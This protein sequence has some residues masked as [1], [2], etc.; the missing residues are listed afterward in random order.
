MPVRKVE[1]LPIPRP[2]LL[3]LALVAVVPLGLAAFAD[4]LVWLAAALGVLTLALAALDLRATPAPASIA[5]ERV[6][7]PQ[8]SSVS[9]TAAFSGAPTRTELGVRTPSDRVL[10]APPREEAPAGLDVTGAASSSSS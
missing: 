9:R 5:V 6:T 10:R 3:A 1:L 8:L 7:E 2:R 4:P